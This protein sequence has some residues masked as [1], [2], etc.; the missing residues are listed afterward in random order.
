M[1]NKK[2]DNLIH[3][4]IEKTSDNTFNVKTADGGHFECTSK[5]KLSHLKS[6]NNLKQDNNF[7]GIG[8]KK[9]L[10]CDGC[11]KVVLK[12]QGTWDKKFKKIIYKCDNCK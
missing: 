1:G 9:D 11:K 5:D 12:V 7:H 10:V 6:N 3:T 8:N 4:K 2:D